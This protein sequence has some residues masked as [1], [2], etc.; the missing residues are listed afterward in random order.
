MADVKSSNSD[1]ASASLPHVSREAFRDGMAHLAGA[2]NIVT[3]DGPAGRA[4]FTATAVCSVTDT[5]PTLLV[6]V[7]LNSSVAHSFLEN[8]AI[9]VN[10]VGPDLDA[11]AMDFGG[12]LPVEDRFVEEDWSA[13]VTGAPCLK[14]ASVS[15]DCQVTARQEIGT[16]AVLFCEVVNVTRAE[17]PRASVYYARKF[18]AL[19]S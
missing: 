5:P 12:K 10:T 6:C 9:C 19:E 1:Q 13:G 4:G 14:G 16:H 2:V 11:L 17:H 18:H 8:T 7:N 3:T 15:F